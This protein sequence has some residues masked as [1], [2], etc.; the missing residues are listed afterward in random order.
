[1]RLR[2]F[3]ASVCAIDRTS[4]GNSSYPNFFTDS[5]LILGFLSLALLLLLWQSPALS[6][7]VDQPLTLPQC[8]ALAQ[9]APSTV[10]Q[11][12]QQL[13]AAQYGQKS[14]LANFLPQMNIVNGFTY[15]S[16]LLYDRGVFSFVALNGVREYLTV[17]NTALEV[18][19]SGRLRGIYERARA[20]REAAEANVAIS[21]RDLGVNVAIAFYRLM[22]TRKLA[23]AADENAR[24][25][26]EFQDKV[27]QLVNGGEASKADLSRATAEAAALQRT[28]S[29][30]HIAAEN[31]NH[32]LASYWTEDVAKELILAGDLDEQLN[33]PTAPQ[34]SQDYL[35]RPEFGL[36][37]AQIAGWKADSHIARAKMLPQ[38]SMNFEYGFDA[39]QLESQNRGYAGFVHFDIPVF[40]FFRA[41]NEK[42]S[43][44]EQAHAA[45]TKAV[46]LK[47][48]YSRAY[49]DALAQVNGIY[50]QL[51]ITQEGLSAAQESVRLSRLRFDGG[52]GTALD[53]VT[54]ENAL[55]QAQIDFYST[56]A[57]YLNAQ[58]ALKVASGQ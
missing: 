21:E 49:Q 56:R 43:F 47:R 35:R 7:S 14:A 53:V 2:T 28:A 24:A 57:D 33:A 55:V 27:Q 18:D 52:E 58:S 39:N 19:T 22:L 5:R 38:L 26:V 4:P 11:A 13:E 40:D 15:N 20:N 44:D 29:A 3:T 36:L 51:A 48:Q 46:I 6:Q 16:P 30:M 23:A 37:R 41:S 42:R 17:G 9:Q 8:V 1:M 34:A 54:A 50:G 45:E 32:E 10:K 31:A 12:R 25:G